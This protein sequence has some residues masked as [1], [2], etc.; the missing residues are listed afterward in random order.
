MSSVL[1]RKTVSR[2]GILRLGAG[3]AASALLA[4]CAPQVVKETVIVAGTPQ[5]VEKEITKVVETEQVV[6]RFHGR[7]GREGDLMTKYAQLFNE[8]H[9]PD[10]FVKLEL[11]PGADYFPKLSTLIAGGTIGDGFWTSSVEGMYRFAA[12]NTYIPLDDIVASQ[13]YDLGAF[14]PEA[15]DA[16]SYQGKLHALPRG[17]HPGWA[18]LIYN[19]STFDAAGAPYPKSSDLTWEDALA[20]AQAVTDPANGVF[21]YLPN[22]YWF[23]LE[24]YVR[25]WGGELIS[26]DGTKS[27][28]DSPECVAAFKFFSDMF[29]VSKVAP[30]A[31][32]MQAGGDQMW[33][34]GKLGMEQSGYWGTYL[35]TMVAPEAFGEVLSPKGPGGS[36]GAVYYVD[37]FGLTSASKHPDEAFIYMAENCTYQAG[38]D[39]W[40][41]AQI[42]PG[43]RPDVWNSDAAKA[44]P[45]FLIARDAFAQSRLPRMPANLRETEF[46]KVLADGLQPIWLGQK[47]TDEVISEVQVACQQVL[48]LPSL[49]S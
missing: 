16:C 19:K 29:H 35:K 23:Q 31:S 47:T 34:S 4:A 5:V 26:E 13:A 49:A 39:L 48:D 28:V 40:Q 15:V 9:Q 37:M 43:A 12:T 1:D 10:I 32:Q 33:V 36:I 46:S 11:F 17:S 14:H 21:G 41:V 25:C 42:I 45:N 44:D 20:S 22:T 2:R 7:M 8:K 27:L 18:F 24:S 30:L 6:I 3:L 38:M